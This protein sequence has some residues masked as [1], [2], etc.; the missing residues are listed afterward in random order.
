M[1]GVDYTTDALVSSIQRRILLPDAQNLYSPDDLIAMAS[2]ELSSTIE[3]LVHSVQQEYWVVKVDV[4]LVVNQ[5]NYTLPLR[6]IVNGLRLVT[7][8]DNGGN[9]IEFPLLS[10]TNG[11]DSWSC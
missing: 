7:L 9:E 4:P 3:P 6:G 8:L 11:P 2:E 10:L 5:T 1:A